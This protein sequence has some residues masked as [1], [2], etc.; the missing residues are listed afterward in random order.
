MP[1]ESLLGDCTGTLGVLRRLEQDVKDVLAISISVLHTFK[2]NHF[3]EELNVLVY[4]RREKI[5]EVDCVCR[6]C[7][8]SN[9]LFM[10][11]GYKVK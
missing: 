11:I 3:G 9:T 1:S 7:V 10:G 5:A 2:A 8:I 6:E 4:I